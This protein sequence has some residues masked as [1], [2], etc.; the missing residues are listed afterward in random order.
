[1]KQ[2]LFA[3]AFTLLFFTAFIVGLQPLSCP[4]E[5][6]WMIEGAIA[7]AVFIII[8]KIAQSFYE[9]FF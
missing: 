5:V 8:F 3:A 2:K 6:V 9:H 7:L 4:Q 1:M